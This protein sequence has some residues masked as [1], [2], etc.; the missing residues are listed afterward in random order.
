MKYFVGVV[1]VFVAALLFLPEVGTAEIRNLPLLLAILA[2]IVIHFAIKGVKHAVLAQKIRVALKNKGFEIEISSIFYTTAKKYAL[3]YNVRTITR[4]NSYYS[5]YF[6]DENTLE[7]Y[8]TNRLVVNA[9]KAK[10]ATPTKHTET[11]RVGL[12]RKFKWAENG[13]NILVIDK[14]PVYVTDSVRKEALGNGNKICG[15]ISIYDYNGFCEFLKN[16]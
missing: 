4:K 7:F 10:G 15:R 5:Y 9:I 13:E 8:K 2:I 16:E 1:L 12:R 6:K 11:R 3:I 14:F